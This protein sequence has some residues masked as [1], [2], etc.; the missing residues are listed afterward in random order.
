MEIGKVYVF[1]ASDGINLWF[2]PLEVLKN[3]NLKGLKVDGYTSTRTSK[4]VSYS[5]SGSSRFI[6][7]DD[8]PPKLEAAIE[9][10]R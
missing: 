9:A 8:I 5:V 3:G 1:E 7:T 6:Q 4:P 2:A 10:R